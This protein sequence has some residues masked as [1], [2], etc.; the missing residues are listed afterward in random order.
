M[1]N[2]ADKRIAER[3]AAELEKMRL[4]EQTLF[5]KA[6]TNFKA[7]VFSTFPEYECNWHHNIMITKLQAFAE[8]KIKNLIINIPPQCGKLIDDAFPILT[9][10]GWTTHGD[11][12]IGML[13]FDGNG[14]PTPI[15]SVAE[16]IP[17]NATIKINGVKFRT[18]LNHEWEVI[19]PVYKDN[20]DQYLAAWKC[21]VMT[22]QEIIRRK[23]R[24]DILRIRLA[25]PQPDIKREVPIP[26]YLMGMWLSNK[27]AKFVIERP[28]SDYDFDIVLQEENVKLKYLCERDGNKVYEFPDFTKIIEDNLMAPVKYIPYSYYLIS[29]TEKLRLLEGILEGCRLKSLGSGN[30]AIYFADHELFLHTKILMRS[31]DFRVHSFGATIQNHHHPIDIDERFFIVV[32]FNV[33]VSTLAHG[34]LDF[35]PRVP[36][37]HDLYDIEEVEEEHSS[38][39]GRCIQVGNPDGL[40]LI[41]HDFIVTHNSELVSRKLPA[42]VLGQDP[43]QRVVSCTYAAEFS[44]RMNRDVQ[45]TMNMREYRKIFPGS[46]INPKGNHAR[47]SD[48]VNTALLFE[49]IG[50]RGGLQSTSIGGMITGVSMDKGIIDDP[51]KDRMEANSQLIRDNIWDWYVDAFLTRC[52]NDT[53]Q[54]ITMTRWHEDDLVGRLLK[55][56][57]E[58]WETIILPALYEVGDT[59]HPL[60]PRAEGDPLWPSKHSLD[61]ILKM[62]KRSLQNFTSLQQQRPA[63]AEGGIVLLEWFRYYDFPEPGGTVLMSVDAAFKE[64]KDTDYVVIQVWLIKGPNRYLL[65]QMRARM[66]FLKTLDGI[67]RMRYKYPQCTGIL[68]EEKANGAA[69]ISTLRQTVSGV[70]AIDPK[71]SKEA[72]LQAVVPVFESGCVY[73]PSKIL[74]PWVQDYL[75]EFAMFP[76]GAHDDQV[77][78][79]S[80]LLHYANQH[81]LN[82]DVK[83]ISIEQKSKYLNITGAI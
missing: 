3:K 36:V 62:K 69:I 35:K 52:H 79:T 46:R 14:N 74:N 56:E 67:K 78:A 15:V 65:D 19:Y 53:Q 39:P 37:I 71:E 47:D 64:T 29:R 55:E 60:D 77:D 57:P 20:K 73:L 18:H 40:Y 1:S 5:S 50:K 81:F 17:C 25:S 42:F 12:Q 70:V 22:T 54:L 51:L 2:L 31:L 43:N 11:L 41:G 27:Y 63:P 28:A 33:A 6:R 66:D 32:N 4:M 83:I 75:H 82:F 23:K 21:A 13:V 10:E 9:T 24:G 72:R 8:G 30:H 58:N 7:F 61:K 49:M 44:K 38:R 16:P 48:E 76:N 45:R 34:V 26:A 59:A 80:Q 68:I